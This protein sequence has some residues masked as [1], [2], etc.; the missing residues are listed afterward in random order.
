MHSAPGRHYREG[1][2][3]LDLFD[4]FPNEKAAEDRFEQQRWDDPG[5]HCKRYGGCDK[6]NAVANRTPIPIGAAI[7]VV[8]LVSARDAHGAQQDSPAS[9]SIPI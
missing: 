7:A 3:L 2:S 6:V 4:L 8:I 5:L 9:G 1:I